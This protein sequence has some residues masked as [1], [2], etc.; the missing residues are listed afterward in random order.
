MAQTIMNSTRNSFLAQQTN[1]SHMSSRTPS[2]GGTGDDSDSNDEE[3][4]DEGVS[5]DED[6]KPIDPKHV[7]M[8]IGW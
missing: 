1:G 8:T 3:P 5:L 2:T 7:G 4:Q 6:D